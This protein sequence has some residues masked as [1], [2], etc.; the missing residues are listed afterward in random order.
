MKLL[1]VLKQQLKKEPNYVTDDGELKKWVVLNKAQNFDEELI[2]LLLDNDELKLKFFV[3]VKDSLVFNQNL[4][5]QFLEQKNYLNDSYTHYKNKV[6][7]TIDG[8]YLKQRNEV[9]LVW[10]FK[11]C[12]L[13]GGQSRE[14]QEREEI[15]F[16]EVLAQ[17]EITQLLE[18]KVLTNFK[19]FDKNG[20]KS[21]ISFN[22]DAELNKKRGLPKNTITDNLIIKGNNLLTL[23]SLKE[24]FA[25]KVKL[26]YIDPPY[27][28]G[29]T[30]ETFTYNNSFKH[31]TWLTFMKNRL[32]VAKEFLK[33][34]GF[35]A[36]TIDHYELFYIGALLDEIFSREN[37]IGIVTIVHKPEGR[38]QEK[39]FGT[40][41]EFMLV[42]AKNKEI[43]EFENV[44]LDEKQREKFDQ[45]DDKGSFRYKNFIRLTDGKYAL[46]EAKP[47]FYYPIYVSSDLKDIS[48]TKKK[49]YHEIYPITE[50]GVERTWKTKSNTFKKYLD[51]GNIEAI[52]E[53]GIIQIYEKLRESQVIKTHWIK[54][55]YHAYHH[56]TKVLE[57]TLGRKAFSF[58][59]SI[60]AVADSIK[61]MTEPN[62]IILDFFSGS[63]TTGH[64]IFNL[65]NEEMANR[66]FILAEQLED[67]M[68][69]SLERLRNV[70]TNNN[71][72]SFIYLEIKKYN[73]SFIDQIEAAKDTETLLEIW[74]SMK[75]KSFLNYNVDIQEQ[76]KHL[77]EFKA[78][79]I[80]NQKKLLLKLLDLNQ[81]YVNRSS[82]NDKDFACTD[83]EKAVTKD[84]YQ[85]KD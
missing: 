10:P 56:G 12:F 74:E 68:A 83:E 67:H 9:A 33:E 81:L 41:N 8:K 70:I 45:K 51:E 15:F 38:N 35:I 6:G 3:K 21:E 66:Q 79:T 72:G 24:E 62:D 80:K 20:E 76:E 34:T 17:D 47:E 82:L 26:I 71:K 27:N 29:G 60:H 54:S 55:E 2:S 53:D 19:C 85:I 73:Q 13:E 75:A 49:N 58:P 25:G 50:K 61:L 39:F 37:R 7:L 1:E 40:S 31:S 28:T 30:E 23:H 22:R 43:A 69:I 32:N 42:Y 11:D 78:D 64:A 65:N 84:F 36:L 4:F 46:R 5:S 77:E 63:A 18:P 14:D 48:L 59:K 57:E 52:K 44:I 16:N